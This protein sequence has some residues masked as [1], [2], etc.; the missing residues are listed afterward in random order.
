MAKKTKVNAEAATDIQAAEGAREQAA[1][2]VVDGIRDK[3]VTL[4]A[5]EL[6]YGLELSEKIGGLQHGQF[7]DIAN[8]MAMLKLLYEVKEHKKYRNVPIRNTAGQIVTT[9]TWEDFCEA[10][11]LARESVDRDLRTIRD[12]GG[13]FLEVQHRLGITYSDIAIIRAGVLD[14]EPE[15]RENALALMEKAGDKEELKAELGAMGIE[16]EKKDKLI[17][18]LNETVA[19]KERL[20]KKEYEGRERAELKLEKLTAITP[21]E[22]DK[23]RADKERNAR[24]TFLGK[25]TSATGQIAEIANYARAAFDECGPDFADWINQQ[26]SVMCRTFRVEILNAGIDVDFESEFTVPDFPADVMESEDGAAPESNTEAA[27]VAALETES[28]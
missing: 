26:V 19:A 20:A 21:A 12:L 6:E 25:V 9:K 7:V 11:G 10:R 14:M 13:D 16:I 3:A 27:T 15:E 5:G 18:E 17:R 4:H 2:L 22:N 8:R 23:A 1:A 28:Q 24:I